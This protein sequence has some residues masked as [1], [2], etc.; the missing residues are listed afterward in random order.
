MKFA[1]WIFKLNV[2]RDGYNNKT[3]FVLIVKSEPIR[4]IAF[5]AMLC[6]HAQWHTHKQSHTHTQ[7]VLWSSQVFRQVIMSV[8]NKRAPSKQ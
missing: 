3:P 4:L 2:T 8:A 1:I 7:Q 6:S 5:K